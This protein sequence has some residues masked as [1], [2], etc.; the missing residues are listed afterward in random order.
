MNDTET[1]VLRQIVKNSSIKI[2]EI[3]ANIN[4]SEKTVSRALKKL[5]EE[6]FIYR[7]GDDFR[8]E[9]IVNKD[10]YNK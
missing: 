7:E 8:G 2:K 9:R 1:K 10:L 4:K 3:A 6:N 5:K